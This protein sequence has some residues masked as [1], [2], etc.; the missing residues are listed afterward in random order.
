M[1]KYNDQ[2]MSNE[3]TPPKNKIVA[4]SEDYTSM[5]PTTYT[6]KYKDNLL[7]I[8]VFDSNGKQC[9]KTK[10]I[11]TGI[12][13]YD[14]NDE[15]ILKLNENL[16][17]SA[18]LISKKEDKKEIAKFETKNTTTTHHKFKVEFSNK[19][20]EVSEFLNIHCTSSYRGIGVFSGDEKE[21]APMICRMINS[22]KTHNTNYYNSYGVYT[23]N[24]TVEIAPNV[25]NLF[26]IAVMIYIMER[27]IYEV[28]VIW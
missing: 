1:G 4:V 11:V 23:S 26:M 14:M 20:G 8:E 17:P 2:L 15:Q 21:G 7:S 16:F 27:R 10:N 12:G 28:H 9:F 18:K 19:A 13:I 5:E 22:S 25:D 24:Y 6:V 3:L